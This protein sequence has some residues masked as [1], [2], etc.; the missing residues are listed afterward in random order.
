MQKAWKEDGW[1]TLVIV[2]DLIYP[3]VEILTVTWIN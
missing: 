1:S 2:N 3:T